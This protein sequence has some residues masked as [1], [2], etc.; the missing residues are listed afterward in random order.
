MADYF[1][2]TKGKHTV[3]LDSS[4]VNSAARLTEQGY[5]KQF[6][7][8]HAADEKQA[9]ARFA[10]IR[11]DQRT[12]QY[13]FLAGAATMRLIGVLTAM[14]TFF[15]GVKNRENDPLRYLFAESFA[16]NVTKY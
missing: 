12:D 1:F 6:E 8:V 3:A 2:Y 16:Q 9:L 4:G 5:E 11:R 10:A 13:N 14:A 15:S 7:E